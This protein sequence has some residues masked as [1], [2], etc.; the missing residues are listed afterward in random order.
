MLKKKNIKIGL[1]TNGTLVNDKNIKEIKSFV[2]EIGISLDGASS[3][4]N[5]KIRGSGTF[6]KIIKAI[7]IIKNNQIPLTLYITI[8]KLNLNDFENILKLALSLRVEFIRINEVSLRGRAYKNRKLLGIN[9][10]GQMNLRKYLI[11]II[12]RVL[13]QNHMKI[14]I[15]NRCEINPTTVFISSLG[16]L[17]PCVEI[18]QKIPGCYLGNILHY[19]PEN[20]KKL[21]KIFSRFKRIKCPYQF[22]V[23]KNFT[24]CLNNPSIKCPYIKNLK[25]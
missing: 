25:H 1:L 20:F 4:I 14:F 17:Y 13:G 21:A 10:Q 18:F 8:N 15:T 5:A 22:I 16:Y 9:N 11:T 24:I 3:Q 7:S 23:G 6:K 12:K 19:T 2:D